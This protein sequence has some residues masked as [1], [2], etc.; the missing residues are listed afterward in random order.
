MREAFDQMAFVDAVYTLGI[1]TTL[2]LAMWAW[3]DMRRAERRREESR[4]K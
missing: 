4:R 1:A 3:R 2:A